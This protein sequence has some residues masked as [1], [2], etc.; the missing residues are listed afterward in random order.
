MSKNLT[1]IPVEKR[2]LESH[3]VQETFLKDFEKV[4][5][6]K[7]SFK[8]KNKM[9][10]SMR[11]QRTSLVPLFKLWNMVTRVK[12]QVDDTLDSSG[13]VVVPDDNPEA[14]FSGWGEEAV[15]AVFKP[16]QSPPQ[17]DIPTEDDELQLDDL[18]LDPDTVLK[19]QERAKAKLD[20][21]MEHSLCS[22]QV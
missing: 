10:A 19:I 9:F 20:K 15:S 5:G 7:A 2:E 22:H 11:S 21:N 6:Y 12:M 18:E 4:P 1:L 3:L 13:A 14:G 16:L 17:I 8:F